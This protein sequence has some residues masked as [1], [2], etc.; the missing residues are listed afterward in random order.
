MEVV[1]D[2]AS[3]SAG[4]SSSP[5]SCEITQPEAN[6]HTTAA[7]S[8]WKAKREGWIK[9]ED[10]SKPSEDSVE[11]PVSVTNDR[12]PRIILDEE[13]VNG[14]HS[15]ERKKSLPPIKV[16]EKSSEIPIIVSRAVYNRYVAITQNKVPATF[17]KNWFML[18]CEWMI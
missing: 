14:N 16:P 11:N 2:K 4:E 6:G 7:K 10:C 8:T 18:I 17:Q 3:E 15:P 13:H 5:V 12:A 1:C 9:P